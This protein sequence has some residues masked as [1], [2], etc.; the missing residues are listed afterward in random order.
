MSLNNSPDTEVDQRRLGMMSS[1][2]REEVRCD[3]HQDNPVKPAPTETLTNQKGEEPLPSHFR[4]K[5]RIKQFQ[6]TMTRSA[7]NLNTYP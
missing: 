5:P 4:T 7:C 6:S 3:Y 2:D 1:F